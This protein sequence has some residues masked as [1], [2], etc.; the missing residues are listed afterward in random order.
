MPK[1]LL[2][3]IETM[4]DKAYVWEHYEANVISYVKPWYIMSFAYKWSDGR[5]KAYS[6]PDFKGYKRDPTDD[7]ELCR[8]LW[9]LF[10]EADIIVAHNGN[11]FDI[12]KAQ[13]KFVE[14]GFRP[15]RPFKSVDTKLVA[16]RYFKFNSNKLDDLGKFLHIGQKMHTGGW[17]LWLDCERGDKKAWQKMVKYNKRDVELLE[18]IYLKL[19]PW[20]K[21]HPNYNLI[22]DTYFRCRVCGSKDLMKQGRRATHSGLSQQFSCNECGN[23]SSAP[24]RDDILSGRVR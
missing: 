6:L 12:K 7:K 21:D 3:D 20:M 16:K 23:W 9:K 10:N 13:A 5:I 14:H 8:E 1:L 2:F 19:R 11:A 4:A 15:P 24:I 17:Q 18:K 22:S